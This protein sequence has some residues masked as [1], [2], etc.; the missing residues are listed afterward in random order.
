MGGESQLSL[1]EKLLALSSLFLLCVTLFGLLSCDFCFGVVSSCL[2][3]KDKVG[4]ASSWCGSGLEWGGVCIPV[5]VAAE[6]KRR[7]G[8]GWGGGE[9]GTASM[10]LGDKRGGQGGLE[11]RGVEL[12]GEAPPTTAAVDGKVD[13]EEEGGRWLKTVIG[14]QGL[15]SATEILAQ[16]FEI[17]GKIIP[18]PPPP[19]GGGLGA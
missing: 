14:N 2:C 5:L 7:G 1:V 8:G 15:W 18:P 16:G 9:E 10:L 19:P 13:E 3:R 6:E 4:V 17:H 11:E 12:E